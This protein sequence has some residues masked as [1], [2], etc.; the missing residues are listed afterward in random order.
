MSLGT[1]IFLSIAGG[2]ALLMLATVGVVAAAVYSA[3]TIDVDV[4]PADGGRFSVSVPAALANLAVALVPSSVVRDASAELEPVL[5][6]VREAGQELWDA[7][8]FVLVEVTGPDENI[9][10]EKRDGRLIVLI[11]A[12]GDNVR[13]EVP[14]NTLRKVTRRLGG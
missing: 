14:M 5:P 9:K 2:I 10:V 13:V 7:P 11:D 3:G 4:R 1:K 8:D 12:D 6:A